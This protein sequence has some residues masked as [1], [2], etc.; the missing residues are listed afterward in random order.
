MSPGAWAEGSAAAAGNPRCVSQGRR[1]APDHIREPAP[2]ESARLRA[3]RLP[4]PPL[5]SSFRA[6]MLSTTNLAIQFDAKPLFEHVSVKFGDGNRYGLIG[7]NGC[8][9]VDADEDAW[10]RTRA[11]R[12]RSRAAGRAAARQAEPEPVRLRGR[13]RA[14]RRDA[15]PRRAVAARCSERDRIYADPD[16]TDADYMRAAELE[17]KVAEYGWLHRRGAGGRDPDRRGHRRVEARPADARDTARPEAARAA[18]AG[19]V[20]APRRAAARRAHQQP[21]H[22]LDRLARAAR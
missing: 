7:A 3:R 20:L 1:T 18:R 12:R 10:Q 22:P 21:R 15:G 8:R 16:A 2:P 19:A 4:G 14:R 6:A 17:G 13:T 11:E 9:E 5:D